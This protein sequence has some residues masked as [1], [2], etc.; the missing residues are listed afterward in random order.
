M[1]ALLLPRKLVEQCV[2]TFVVRGGALGY[3]VL[4]NTRRD[5]GVRPGGHGVDV[6]TVGPRI[7]LGEL[8]PELQEGQ[9]TL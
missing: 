8:Y 1:G 7:R 2:E 5:K 4:P 9:L 3:P 6:K